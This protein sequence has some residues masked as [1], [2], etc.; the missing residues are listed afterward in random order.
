M[1]K[2]NPNITELHKQAEAELRERRKKTRPLPSTDTDTR[3]LVHELQVHQI[4]LEMQNEELVQARVEVETFLRQYTDLYDFAPVGYFTLRRD[5]TIQQ[6]NLAGATLLGAKAERSKLVMRHFGV[7]V[8][9][10]S[11]N[12]FSAFLEKVF[13]GKCKETCEALLLKDGAD[14]FWA[15][16]EAI[17]NAPDGKRKHEVCSAVVS[18]ITERVQAE[19]ALR[20]LNA[21]DALTGLYNR[22]FFVADMERLEH[23]RQFPVSIVM[24]DVDDLKK[25]N[26]QEGH[27]AGDAVLKRVAEALTTAFR[28]ED[29][30][31][32]IGGDEFAVLLPDT[33]AAT[34][35]VLLERVHQV[36]QDNNSAHTETQIRLSIGVST[37]EN[38]MPLSVVLT[39]ADANMY[40]EKRGNDVS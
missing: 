16:I 6:V 2:T 12:I 14:P 19:D 34:A 17:F 22:S 5:G 24:A 27:A 25:T 10:Q 31:A 9:D 3:R 8:S 26:D 4:E 36:I 39:K 30:V 15:R 33:N 20:H 38:P 28:T 23:G 18:D 11:R 40:R 1:A 29:V 21:H 32:R 35:K 7:F 13:I 37:A